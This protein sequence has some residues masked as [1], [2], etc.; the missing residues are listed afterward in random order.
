[1]SFL[2]RPTTPATTASSGGSVGGSSWAS[3]LPALS[4]FLVATQ[5]SD[6]ESR[7]PGSLT[8]FTDA[9]QWK[10]CLSDKALNRIAFVSAIGPQEALEAAERGLM[11]DSLDW[12]PQ[13]PPRGKR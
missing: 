11:A 3:Q 1:M 4:E 5:W 10:I 2:K 12:R 7:L 13:R 9:G 8:L 6:G